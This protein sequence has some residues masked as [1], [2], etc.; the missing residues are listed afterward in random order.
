MYFFLTASL[1]S[2]KSSRVYT[3]QHGVEELDSY[4]AH[5]ALNRLCQHQIESRQ[6]IE[7]YHLVSSCRPL[8]CPPSHLSSL[9]HI[10]PISSHLTLSHLILNHPPSHLIQ[11]SIHLESY[12][13]PLSLP[14][15]LLT[16]PP[17]FPTALIKLPPNV[18]LLSAA[19]S[20]LYRASYSRSVSSS[21]SCGLW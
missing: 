8:T 21:N 15:Y 9:Y 11:P 13:H 7:P 6:T 17:I 19:L 3:R 5:Q 20:L 18:G 14:P 4:R 10:H 2:G 12:H 1:R 16:N